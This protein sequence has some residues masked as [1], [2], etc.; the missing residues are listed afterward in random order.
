M[1]F[2][3]DLMPK[4]VIRKKFWRYFAIIGLAVFAIAYII[5]AIKE[6]KGIN[7]FNAS[8]WSLW[9]SIH[10]FQIVSGK[11]I[12]ALFGKQYI[13]VNEKKIEI[14]PQIFKKA[15]IINWSDLKSIKMKPTYLLVKSKLGDEIKID[16][17]LIDYIAVQ[18][19]KSIIKTLVQKWKVELEMN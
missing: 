12:N 4:Y 11:S 17:K 13:H 7:I 2:Y 10:I 19:L 16:F 3:Y 5:L 6:P 15:T 1:D 9:A 8:F 14:K 18:D